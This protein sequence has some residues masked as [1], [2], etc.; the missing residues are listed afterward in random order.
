MFPTS[1]DHRAGAAVVAAGL[2]VLL[3]A[4]GGGEPAGV[5]K[6][7]RDGLAVVVGAH[8]N[9]PAPQLVSE[10]QEIVRQAVHREAHAAVLVNDSA[11]TILAQ[12]PLTITAKNDAGRKQNIADNE[13]RMA[14]TI[15]AAAARTREVDLLKTLDL[16]ARAV[17]PATGRRTILVVDSGL[18]TTGAIKFQDS[19]MLSADP[20][21]VAEALQQD[22]VLPNLSGTNVV[23]S[24][25]G[26]TG[27]PQPALNTAQRKALVAIWVAIAERGGA[28]VTVLEAPLSGQPVE[29]V[30]P[31]SIVP[32]STPAVR[33]AAGTGS[34]TVEL[35]QETVAFVSNS[36]EYLDITAARESI[37]PIANEILASGRAVQL[38]G[39]TASAG[40]VEGRMRLSLAR[41]DAVKATLVSLGVPSARISTQGVGSDW[42]GYT[43][44]RDAAGRLVPRLAA[45]NRKVMIRLL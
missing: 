25:L 5:S 7:A 28:N 6:A 41:A 34:R 14:K 21:E 12:G 45:K 27:P 1:A 30:P 40:E 39:A 37:A 17:S 23:F 32:V 31:V 13:S 43:Q 8:A 9:A 33:L 20:M 36:A 29:G 2:S 26:D 19:G 3:A 44:D 22:G 42:S 4:C 18:Q 10:A 11:G 16:A 35:T 38:T 24:G 15:A